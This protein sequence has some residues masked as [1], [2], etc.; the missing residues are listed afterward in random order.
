MLNTAKG[1]L[2]IKN[3]NEKVDNLMCQVIF[4]TRKYTFDERIEQFHERSNPQLHKK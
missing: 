1:V 2:T 4:Y 3:V